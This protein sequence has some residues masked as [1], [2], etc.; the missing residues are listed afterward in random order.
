MP[1]IGTPLTASATRVLLCGSGELGKE[2][3]IELQRLGV[4]VIAV[5]RYANA[6]AMQVAHRSHVID[7]LDGAALRG[8][9]EQEQPH[10]IVP[11]IEAIATAT[12]VELEAEGFTVIPTA[13]AAQLTMNRE[14]IRRL[15]AEELGLPTSPYH[16]ADSLAECR[17][18]AVALGFP[19]LIKPVMSSSGKGQTLLRSEADIDAAWEYAQAGGRAGRGRVI[20]EGFID[21]DYEITLLTVRHAGGTTF[22]QP[23]GHR[24]EKGDYQ[25][26]WQ[27]QPVGAA[28][29][30]QAERIALAVTDALG[31]RGVFGV[32]LFI[33]GEQVW[34]CEISPRPHD[35]GL[36]T[37][38][39]QDLSEFALHARAILGLPIP[40]I[41]QL[42]P[43]ASAVILA[44]GESTEVCF[45]NLEGALCE[46][47]TSLR[48]FG[49]PG[50]SG[51]RRMGV[52]LAR[53]ESLET[54]RAKAKRAAAAVKIQ[55]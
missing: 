49:K 27:P 21:F 51:Q 22:C 42:G 47:D 13:R 37:L 25:E 34:F 17:A 16:F 29:L 10:Y 32:E 3:V 48:L 50:V 45:G 41:R 28:A 38:V 9:I 18:A 11:E 4:E 1:R 5:D 20:V 55:L 43:S 53:D 39:S 36:V 46:P 33:K 24:Q 7:M 15:A 12:L 6:P 30:A 44:E 54:A 26:S 19:C 52:A 23:V 31:G 35:T 14:G 40:V 2:L 8:V